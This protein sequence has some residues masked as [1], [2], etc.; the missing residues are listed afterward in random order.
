MK[1]I[2]NKLEI[3]KLYKELVVPIAPLAS[4][5]ETPEEVKTIL[6]DRFLALVGKDPDKDKLTNIEK[7]A[8]GMSKMA[9]DLFYLMESAGKL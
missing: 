6:D 8:Y 5:C 1:D 4:D 7:E 9:M 2:I 3:E